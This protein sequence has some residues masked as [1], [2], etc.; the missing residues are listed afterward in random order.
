LLSHSG[1]FFSLCFFHF[2]NR[3]CYLHLSIKI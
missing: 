1:I 2:N 3:I